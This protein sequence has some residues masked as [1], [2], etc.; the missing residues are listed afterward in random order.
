VSSSDEGQRDLFSD[1]SDLDL[2]RQLLAELHD[3]LPGKV[4]R[5]R[6]L[7]DLA[8]DLG[9]QGT[10]MPGGQSAYLAWSEARLSFVHGNFVATIQLCQGLLEHLL[11][12]FLH[13][14]D[15][16]PPR[17]SFRQTLDRCK[18]RE[19]LNEADTGDLERRYATPYRISGILTT[20]ATLTEGQCK[21]GTIPVN[22]YIATRSSQLVWRLES[23][24]SHSFELGEL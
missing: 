4:T 24:R 7:T 2:A 21:A 23:S 11:A 13:L 18:A 16:L 10:F 3:D 8:A 20:A 15:D 22:Y 6:L 9:L 14:G 17:I 5:F 12:A 19:T 1:V